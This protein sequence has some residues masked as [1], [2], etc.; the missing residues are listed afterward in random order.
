V[1]KKLGEFRFNGFCF[2][3]N[4]GYSAQTYRF[5]F[6]NYA[7]IHRPVWLYSTPLVYVED[8]SIK[9]DIVGNGNFYS[10]I[11]HYDVAFASAKK[12]VAPKVLV[13]VVNA[14]GT[15]TATG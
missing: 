9:T 6:F 2:S 11:V 5:D 1:P 13:S 3:P 12:S 4:S 14:D 15:V 10:G 7:G 8:I